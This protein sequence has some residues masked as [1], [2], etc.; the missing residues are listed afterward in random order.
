MTAANIVCNF[1]SPPKKIEHN[2][3]MTS[4]NKA[5]HFDDEGGEISK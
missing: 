1:D 2:V 3:K 4:L 5:C